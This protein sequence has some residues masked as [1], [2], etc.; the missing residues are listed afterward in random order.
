MMSSLTWITKYFRMSSEWDSF[1]NEYFN[2][3]G[4][5]P[6]EDTANPQPDQATTPVAESGKQALLPIQTCLRVSLLT[7]TLAQC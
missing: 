5:Q 6:A 3:T 1:M 2:Y 4:P 7:R